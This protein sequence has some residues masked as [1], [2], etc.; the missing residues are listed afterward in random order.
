MVYSRVPGD[1]THNPSE[2]SKPAA[3][4]TPKAE[5]TA[6]GVP[7][8]RSVTG[9]DTDGYTVTV[10]ARDGEEYSVDGG[11]TWVPSVAGADTLTFSG[12]QPGTTCE[13][14]ARKA[15][16]KGHNASPAGDPAVTN[17]PKDGATAKAN[18]PVIQSVEPASVT[19]KG[20]QGEEYV[21]VEKGRTPTDEDWAKARTSAGDVV[22]D[23]LTSGE[24]Y[25]VYSRI[26]GTAITSDKPATFTTPDTAKADQNAPAAPQATAEGADKV[27]V[28]PVAQ[29]Q[30]YSID[31][32]NTWV[33]PAEGAE[34]VVFEGLQPGTTYPVVARMA[35]TDTQNASQPSQP[36]KVKT[37][38]ADQ[39]EPAAPT[40]LSTTPDAITVAGEDGVEYVVVPKGPTPTPEDWTK[41]KSGVGDVVLDGVQ[42][43]GAYDIIG[44]RIGDEGHNPSEPGPAASTTTPREGQTTP[45]KP[46]GVSAK[47]TG[48]DDAA[49]STVTVNPA[50]KGQEYSID[51][52]NTWVQPDEGGKVVFDGLTP[53][54]TYPVVTRKSGDDTHNPSA[55]SAPTTVTAPKAGQTA[56]TSAPVIQST[57]PESITVAA[58]DGEEYSVD[59]GKTWVQPTDGKAVFDGLT[60]GK[61]YDIIGRKAGDESHNP[62]EPGPSATTTTPKLA[63]E[64][65][66]APKAEADGPNAVLVRPAEDG[67][68][69]SIDGQGRTGCAGQR[70]DRA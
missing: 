45:T 53:G 25:D 20:V 36:T 18:T 68:E 51:G 17:V 58:N 69:Y 9:N 19:I 41:A 33:K 5:Q 46:T 40:I 27:V 1:E 59:G 2:P 64:A 38:K 14:I 65:T 44:R 30:E 8:I 48:T 32:G 16:D 3:I 34:Q 50:V 62:S 29:G 37:G 7:V 26:A 28:K 12:L 55:P 56:P 49:T 11:K 70:A 4:S 13:I 22:L 57:T 24:T 21:V 42:P 60:P 43:G 54:G 31:G 47:T 63:G 52:G 61:T 6:P 10:A 15:A 66:G 23:G 67:L 39:E 35:E